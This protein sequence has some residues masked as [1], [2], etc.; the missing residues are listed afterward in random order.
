MRLS[1]ACGYALRALEYLA[2]R[3]G[4]PVAA[5]DIAAGRGV[6]ARF[7]T[8]ALQPLVRAGL[9]ASRK[10][11]GGGYRLGRPAARVTLLEV[12]EA[13]DGPVRGQAPLAREGGL[14]ARLQAVCDRAAELV[15]RRLGE[16][17]L[18][19]LAGKG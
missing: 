15:R 18:S 11:P 9:L 19:A 13:V 2:E 12:V 3:G 8:K 10:G 6:S 4:G 5:H 1:H 16:V 17:R 7:L 14:D